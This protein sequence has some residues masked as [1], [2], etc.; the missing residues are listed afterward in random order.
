MRRKPKGL[1]DR[2]SEWPKS[3]QD[4]A[5]EHEL[6][7]LERRERRAVLG[8]KLAIVL[9]VLASIAIGAFAL[10]H[11]LEDKP[12]LTSQQEASDGRDN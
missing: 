6:D 4:A 12:H 3:L 1:S 5:L 8:L 7:R 2:W 10:A 11:A 9:V